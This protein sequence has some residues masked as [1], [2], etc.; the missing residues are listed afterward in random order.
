[1]QAQFVTLFSVKLFKRR[2]HPKKGIT[3]NAFYFATLIFD[4]RA[5]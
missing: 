1:M 5:A 2:R 3:L 4:L